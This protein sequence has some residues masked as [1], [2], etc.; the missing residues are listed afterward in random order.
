[1]R[2]SDMA[3]DTPPVSYFAQSIDYKMLTLGLLLQSL[4][5]KR[6]IRKILKTSILLGVRVFES[7]DTSI[8]VGGGGIGRWMLLICFELGWLRS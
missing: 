6:I 5:F 4:A 7:T 3:C 1:M 2:L 8:A